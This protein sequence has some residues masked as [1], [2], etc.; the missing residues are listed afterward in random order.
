MTQGNTMIAVDQTLCDECAT[1]VSVCP[2]DAMIL[3]GKIIIDEG[4][5]ISCGNC[6]DVCPFGALSQAPARGKG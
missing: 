6:V 5:C 1:C 2:T 4:K 3:D